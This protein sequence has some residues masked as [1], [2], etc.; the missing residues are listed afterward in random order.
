MTTSPSPA[1]DLPWR[2]FALAATAL[3]LSF[4]LPLWQLFQFARQD[5]LHSFI[6]LMPLVSAYLVWVERKNLPAISPPARAAAAAFSLAGGLALAGRWWA[7]AFALQLASLSFVMLLT[8]AGCWWLGGRRM[9]ALA[10]PFAL[11]L[12]LI[13]LPAFARDG[14]ETGLQVGSAAVADAMFNLVG[15]PVLCDGTFFRLPGMSLRVA[16]E[17]SGI[18]ST[19]VLFITSLVAGKLFLRS[20]WKRAVLTLVVIPLA[21]LRNGF[22][23]LVIG[24]LC[25]HVGPQMIDS[26]IHHQ[27]GPLFFVLSLPPFFLLLYLLRKTDRAASLSRPGDGDKLK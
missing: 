15:T 19:L 23:I 16:P 6:L 4:I 1:P 7:P 11:L 20:P 13:P 2:P 25:V 14:I 27:G 10:Y 24:E 9:R 18:H 3:T 12:F 26:P 22:R 5:E 21:L 17:C 8:A